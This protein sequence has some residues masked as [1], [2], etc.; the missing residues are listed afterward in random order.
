M[1]NRH[2][3]CVWI[4]VSSLYT[5]GRKV[6]IDNNFLIFN[7][8]YNFLPLKNFGMK[9]GC[10]YSTH[11]NIRICVESC[12]L[13][14]QTQQNRWVF[15]FKKRQTHRKIIFQVTFDFKCTYLAYRCT[16]GGLWPDSFV[17]VYTVHQFLHWDQHKSKK[18]IKCRLDLRLIKYFQVNSLVFCVLKDPERSVMREV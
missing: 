1:K 2:A 4:P 8:L 7:R 12:K 11:H 9:E 6:T 5:M 15:C 14:H 18:F 3:N 10:S 13:E 16:F 17:N